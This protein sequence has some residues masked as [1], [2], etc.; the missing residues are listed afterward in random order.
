MK[1]I[2]D[3]K[4]ELIKYFIINEDIDWIDINIVNIN[5]LDLDIVTSNN[6]T[7]KDFN[8]FIEEKIDLYNEDLK[9]DEKI[10]SGFINIWS[11][12]E[13]EFLGIEKP[14]IKKE[15]NNSSFGAIIDNKNNNLLEK[16]KKT[17]PKV[18][19]FYSYKGGVGRTVALIHTATLLA[20]EGK[21]VALIDMDIEAPSFN[22]I[23]KNEIKSKN[24]LVEYLYNKMYDLDEIQ[25]SSMMTKL[26]LSAKGE[27]YVLPTG[28]ISPKYVKR[29]DML[30]ERR[31]SENQYIEDLI[32][33][34]N[35]QYNIDYV[36]IDSR[37]GI[38]NW[39]ALS[40]GEI[41]DEVFLLAY[42]NEENV[43]GTNLILDMLGENK[44]CTVVFSR[45][46]GSVLGREKAESLFNEVNIKQEFIGI[47][48]DSTIAIENR[49]PIEEK[50]VG[51]KKLSDIILEDE[52]NENNRMWIMDNKDKC[53]NILELLKD[54]FKFDSIFTND[55]KKIIDKSNYIIIKDSK[56]DIESIFKNFVEEK[57]K[58]DILDIEFN[59]NKFTRDHTKVKA[60]TYYSYMISFLLANFIANIE[61][62]IYKQEVGS[63]KV[64]H[65]HDEIFSENISNIKSSV[66][67]RIVKLD[68]EMGNRKVLIPID[69]SIFKKKLSITTDDIYDVYMDILN[70]SLEIINISENIQFKLIVDIDNY[71]YYD[72]EINN[73][74][75]NILM[76][77]S[78]HTSIDVRK[79]D[80]RT[81]FNNIVDN[82]NN[83]IYKNEKKS[84]ISFEELFKYTLNDFKKL[85]EESFDKKA[86]EEIF[87][88]K[89]FDEAFDMKLRE[90][91]LKINKEKITK[92]LLFCNKIILENGSIDLIEWLVNNTHGKTEVLNI[93]KQ[94]AKIELG[95]SNNEKSS[96]IT[97][98][99][100]KKVLEGKGN[101]K[102]ILI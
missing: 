5:R 98:E 59:C 34:M 30:K 9:N 85:N 81:I 16:E 57:E 40:I 65:I 49:Y 55:E 27:V 75:A 70:F 91:F 89:A 26:P 86:F 87:D 72:F 95:Y 79:D 43:K 71:E 7:I 17:E 29:L 101:K 20:A 62:Y 90:G 10:H 32:N 1:N 96:I 54:G 93:I 63:E 61:K 11:P 22:E 15:I 23:F 66:I 51:F 3:L 4:N 31:I 76:L 69:I 68:E 73:Y 78:K 42:P 48:Y 41:A 28:E 97:S 102:D 52:I 83:N 38:N 64:D 12:E 77:S 24:G 25:L 21:K 36:L 56:S 80:V 45:I 47:Y 35:R 74:I 8:K 14:E 18:V 92:D 44:K 67:E 13:A 2:Q 50:L 39:G 88:K 99:S 94:A 19:S 58:F 100:F 84:Y 37:T 60:R 82:I 46:D 6:K 53:N 33:E